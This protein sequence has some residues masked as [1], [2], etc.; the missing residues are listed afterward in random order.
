MLVRDTLPVLV[1]RASLSARLTPPSPSVGIHLLFLPSPN[2]GSSWSLR[3]GTTL[4]DPDGL[5]KARVST[6][7]VAT[8]KKIKKSR[9]AVL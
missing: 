5:Y 2:K 8:N 4:L 9:F 6:L 7:E 3:G 1:H